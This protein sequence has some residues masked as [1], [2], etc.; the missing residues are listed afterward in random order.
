MT[1]DKQKKKHKTQKYT[2]QLH[3]EHNNSKGKR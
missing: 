2:R 3:K 1:R